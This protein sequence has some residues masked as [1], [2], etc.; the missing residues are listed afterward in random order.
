MKHAHPLSHAAVTSATETGGFVDKA[1]GL[2]SSVKRR[3]SEEAEIR[4]AVTELEQ[5]DD[6]ALH[7]IGLNRYD[8]EDR[9]RR[10]R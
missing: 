7:D 2:L 5:L 10:H 1:L 9:V 4:H 3:W 6:H 8:I